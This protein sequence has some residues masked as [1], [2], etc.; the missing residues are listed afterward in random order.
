V[1]EDLKDL[2][3]EKET[4]RIMAAKNRPLQAL[5]DMAKVVDRSKIDIGT[6]RPYFE[7]NFSALTRN[8]GTCERILKTPM[9]MAYTRH[10]G[11]FLALYMLLIPLALWGELDANWAIVPASV[12][13]SVFLFGIEELGIQIEEPYTI[14]PMDSMCDS[15]QATLA[16]LVRIEAT[17]EESEYDYLPPIGED[18]K[19]LS[20]LPMQRSWEQQ[21][22]VEQDSTSSEGNP[23]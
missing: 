12:V 13:M 7:P 2:V 23:G 20:S 3:G 9:P 15:M 10:T 1:T 21:N 22:Q 18:A 6:V 5:M 17:T 19:P 16:E 8:I 14:L 4:A 11:R